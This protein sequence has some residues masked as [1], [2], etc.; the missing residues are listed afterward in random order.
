MQSTKWCMLSTA[1]P[2]C[3]VYTSG[4][5]NRSGKE[6]LGK[7]ATVSGAGFSRIEISKESLAHTGSVGANKI[8]KEE[9]R[10][11]PGYGVNLNWS[12]RG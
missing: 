5:T 4:V 11:V 3:L 9:A 8:K 2:I 12:L 6:G 7:P 1:K 10:E